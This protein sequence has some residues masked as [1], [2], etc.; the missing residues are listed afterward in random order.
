MFSPAISFVL[1]R[2]MNTKVLWPL[3]L[4]LSEHALL[5]F[6]LQLGPDSEAVILMCR[7]SSVI[8]LLAFLHILIEA[9]PGSQRPGLVL[10]WPGCQLGTVASERTRNNAHA[11]PSGI[12]APLI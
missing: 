11:N 7:S 6:R 10:G 4:L 5:E 8:F 3:M 9:P 2:R 12:L 1:S